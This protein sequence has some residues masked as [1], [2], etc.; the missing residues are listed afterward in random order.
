MVHKTFSS[1]L[2]LICSVTLVASIMS[3]S[4]LSLLLIK[5]AF[6]DGLTQ[7]TLSA[8]FGD[9]K[10]DLLIKM[11]PPVV[12]TETIQQQ[13]Q[14]PVIQFKLF[15]DKTNQ[16]I[17]HVTYF[18]TID[19]EGKKLLANT[20]HDHNGDL[21]LEMKPTNTS[22]IVVNGDQDPILNAYTGTPENPVIA[23]G[24]IFLQGGLYHFKVQISTIDFD[25]TLIPENKQPTFDGW[26]SVGI[27]QN[28]DIVV[29]GKQIPIKLISYYD[30]PNDFSF[31]NKDMQM[32]IAM[33]FDWDLNRLNKVKIFVHEEIWIP[34]PSALT[35]KTSYSGAVNGIDVTKN[36]VL[37]NSKPQNDVIHFMLPKNTVMQVAD[38][39]NKNGQASIPLMTFTL[40]PGGAAKGV[41]SMTGMTTMSSGN[42]T[43]PTNGTKSPGAMG[44]GNMTTPSSAKAANQTASTQSPGGNNSMAG[45]GSTSGSGN[46]TQSG[47]QTM[48]AA[49]QQSANQT[50]NNTGN[51]LAKI[52]I[53]GKLFGGK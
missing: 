23:S 43:N 33:P 53:I 19:K 20:F 5:P 47:N 8:S 34:K 44:G 18:I 50:G 17:K 26:L 45:G 37:D 40:Q 3:I 38:Q 1:T 10:A 13:G 6:G 24:P 41:S 48:T 52:P 9:R 31:N 25:R 29:N 11:F 42:V 16:G 30:K 22:Q 12:T 14:T 21:H 4:S 7:E 2:L 39:V 49:K 51:P 46:A 15:D 32:K 27:T 28:K 35:S 36:I